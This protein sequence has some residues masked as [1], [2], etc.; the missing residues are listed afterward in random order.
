MLFVAESRLAF[1]PE[2]GN[3]FS[4]ILVHEQQRKAI[5]GMTD[6]IA[7]EPAIV[8]RL[9]HPYRQPGLRS[10]LVGEGE[11][12]RQHFGMR[13]DAERDTEPAGFLRRDGIAEHAH[14]LGL[15]PAHDILQPY[16]RKCRQQTELDFRYGK[17]G[18]V[19]RDDEIRRDGELEAAAIGDAVDCGYDR[20]A[21]IFRRSQHVDRGNQKTA[22]LFR[23]KIELTDV[24][25][26]AERF[27][28]ASRDDGNPDG[29]ILVRLPQS[30]ENSLA[31][32]CAQGVELMGLVE[33]EK[34]DLASGFVI[35]G[36]QSHD[37]TL[38]RLYAP[39]RFHDHDD[40]V[41]LDDFTCVTI[42]RRHHAVDLAAD[43]QFHLHGF[44]NSRD[45]AGRDAVTNRD[46][47]LADHAHHGSAEFAARL[48]GS[49]DVGQIGNGGQ[50]VYTP[51]ILHEQYLI[52]LT[53]TYRF[54]KISHNC[55]ETVVDSRDQVDED[56]VVV[57][58]DQHAAIGLPWRKPD[59]GAGAGGLEMQERDWRQSVVAGRH[60]PRRGF[61]RLPGAVRRRVRRRRA[62]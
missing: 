54:A 62:L 29:V 35:D 58:A 20:L 16:D 59:L 25:A 51:A 60:L 52:V 6:V 33:G 30:F 49:A 44:E 61:A 38:V 55:G 10:D 42:D 22:R 53:D 31:D 15:G 21:G 32:A 50:R 40:R 57:D 47:D 26:G 19:G 13:H 23:I 11:G 28:A 8:E 14:L 24:G 56:L 12:V 46:I 27:V 3:A 9:G 39:V 1:L 45:I 43:A 34:G 5:D 7:T 18:A 17:S 41:A 37:S 4:C 2:S 48:R 36:S